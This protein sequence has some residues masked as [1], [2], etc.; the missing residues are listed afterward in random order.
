MP[1][2]TILPKHARHRQKETR[3]AYVTVVW[4]IFFHGPESSTD[5]TLEPYQWL[6]GKGLSH[7]RS[8]LLVNG[9]QTE[10][11]MISVLSVPIVVAVDQPSELKPS[12]KQRSAQ[13]E[14]KLVLLQSQIPSHLILWLRRRERGE[15]LR[16]RERGEALR[17]APP[18]LRYVCYMSACCQPWIESRHTRMQQQLRHATQLP[19]HT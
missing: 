3:Y 7:H 10:A 12:T 1:Q 17:F 13:S 15:A 11:P 19:K 5:S 16:R 2:K 14:K 9:R 18:N 6:P 4:L 8:H